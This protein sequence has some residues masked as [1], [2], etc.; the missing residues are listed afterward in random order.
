MPH[1]GRPVLLGRMK[2]EHQEGISQ[3][4]TVFTARSTKACRLSQ[5]AVGQSKQ[6]PAVYWAASIQEGARDV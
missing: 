6:V 4:Y 5:Q 1:C 2:K 3:I